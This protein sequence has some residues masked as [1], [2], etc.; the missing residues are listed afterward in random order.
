MAR[1]FRSAS[2]Q[3]RKQHRAMSVAPVADVATLF[4]RR[5]PRLYLARK[6]VLRGIPLGS[7]LS[8]S[9]APL[10]SV[11]Y[12]DPGRLSDISSAVTRATTFR[13]W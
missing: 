5:R 10:L 13:A 6:S 1:L 8:R 4:R 7:F 3:R 12:R 9:L 2:D 11:A